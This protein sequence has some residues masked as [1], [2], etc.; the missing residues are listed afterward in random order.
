MSIRDSK[1]KSM[2]VI[3]LVYLLA[4]AAGVALAYLLPWH[5]LLNLLI[6]DIAA[7]VIVFLFSL[8]FSNASVYDPYWSVLPVVAVTGF[9]FGRKMTLLGILQIIMIWIWGV[10]L[11]GNW[12]YT[13]GNLKSQDW[14]YTRYQNKTGK[15]Y[16]IVNFFGI[17]LMPTLIVY[18]CILPAI[19]VICEQVEG[20]IVGTPFLL[21]SL[22]A[23]ILQ[24]MADLQMHAFRKSHHGELIRTG[25][26]KHSRHP[27][28]LGEIL[29]WW[30]I[31]LSAVISLTGKWYL[32]SGALINTLLFLFISIPLAEERQAKKPGF[33]KYKR[34]TRMLLPIPRTLGLSDQGQGHTAG[35][36]SK[37]HPEPAIPFDPE[38]QYAVIRSS[39]CTG[40]K[41]AG[42]KNKDDG[43]FT[44]VMLITSEAD[45]KS[46]KKLYGID[47]I[48]TEY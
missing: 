2:I 12:A 32:L 42:F 6:T 36:L 5:Y 43:H 19:Y 20:S 28:Y 23:V 13:F 40:E 37:K 10:R 44:E 9:A 3:T 41:V 25:L 34:E 8:I 1:A 26:W 47:T 27:N 35:A 22:L 17:H 15:W 39:I 29:M 16:P 21:I 45:E 4:G 48:K 38:T 11:T 7:T 18:A 31:G 24:G 46:F 30:G 33:A 14:R